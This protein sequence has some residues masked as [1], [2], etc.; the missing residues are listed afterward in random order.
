VF[1]EPLHGNDH[2]LLEVSKLEAV[3]R[4]V[5]QTPQEIF[6]LAH[7]TRNTKY[8]MQLICYRKLNIKKRVFLDVGELTSV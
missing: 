1:I 5:D 8:S 2:V 4:A 7:L 6:V 3:H